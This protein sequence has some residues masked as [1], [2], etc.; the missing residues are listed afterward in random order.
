M[1]KANDASRTSRTAGS[2]W[3]FSWDRYGTCS[4]GS[5]SYSA[6]AWRAH[7]LRTE[8]LAG[9]AFDRGLKLIVMHTLSNEV[10]CKLLGGGHACDDMTN[11]V[12]QIKAARELEAHID[13]ENDCALKHKGRSRTQLRGKWPN[14]HFSQRSIPKCN[15]RAHRF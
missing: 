4:S 14:I 13:Y 1:R 7:L 3:V 10:L 12:L 6:V 5:T 15:A 9:A 2:S 11:V 8:G